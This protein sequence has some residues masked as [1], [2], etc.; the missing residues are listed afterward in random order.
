MLFISVKVIWNFI[1]ELPLPLK[2]EANLDW[3]SGWSEKAK[4][5]ENFI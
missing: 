2:L 4:D 5:I 1:I 3:N